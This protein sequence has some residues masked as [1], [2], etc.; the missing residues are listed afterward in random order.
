M[1]H[2]AYGKGPSCTLVAGGVVSDPSVFWLIGLEPLAGMMADNSGSVS[3][4][5]A[6]EEV[7]LKRAV[8]AESYA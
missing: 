8:I 1:G 2:A 5:V 4:R 6:S 7:R 3:Q